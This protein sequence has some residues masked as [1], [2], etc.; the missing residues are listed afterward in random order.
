MVQIWVMRIFMAKN[1][2]AISYLNSV[3]TLA[4]GWQLSNFSIIKH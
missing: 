3:Q 1:Q 2:D 4:K